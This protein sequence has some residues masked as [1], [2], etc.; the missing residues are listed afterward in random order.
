M[1]DDTMR[2]EV[3]ESNVAVITLKET[4]DGVSYTMRE[5]CALQGSEYVVRRMLRAVRGKN[6]HEYDDKPLVAHG[7]EVYERSF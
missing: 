2:V 3:T 1:E 4:V 6:E 5:V 7:G